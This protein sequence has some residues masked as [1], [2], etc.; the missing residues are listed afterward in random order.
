M[1]K[2]KPL[3]VPTPEQGYDRHEPKAGLLAAIASVT[4][5]IL[6]VFIV[7]VYWLYIRAEDRVY[8]EQVQ[9]KP[10]QELQAIHARE[11]E[12]LNQYGYIDKEKGVVRLTVDRAME[13]VETDY[14]QG[15]VSY[16]TKTYPV[17]PDQPPGGIAAPGAPVAPGT[18]P[19]AGVAGNAPIAQSK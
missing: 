13:L 8:Q 3:N 6:F 16:N 14:K 2:T 4:I 11:E 1:E 7:G 17:K 18:T 12:Q 15:R 5:G 19:A 9:E 10:S